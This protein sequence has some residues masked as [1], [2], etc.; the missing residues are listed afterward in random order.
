MAE[1]IGRKEE[2]RELARC[3]K[4]PKSEFVVVY[5]RRRIGKTF[6][7]RNFF[8]EKYDF[9]FVGQ[10]NCTKE[11]Q[12]ANFAEAIKRYG[13]TNYDLT[14]KTWKDAFNQLRILLENKKLR[15]KKVIFIDEM[16][17]LDSRRSDFVSALEYFWNAWAGNRDDIMFVACGSS[18]SWIVEKILKNRGGLF[19]RVTAQIYLRPFTL[20]EVKD[21]LRSLNF[22]WD[23][24]QI[25]QAYMIL[26]GVP[27]YYSLIDRNLPLAKNI[28]N[29]FFA[30]KNAI[31]RTEFDELF[32]ALFSN[33]EKHIDV[34]K[35]LTTC[36]EG[37]T[38]TEITQKVDFGGSEMTKILDNLE[39]CD[40]IMSSFKT[41]GGKKNKIYR[42]CDFYT[43]FYYKFVNG[44]R[45]SNADFWQQMSK[46]PKL[47][48]WQG[49]SFE[50]LCLL[51]IRQI[52]RALGIDGIM[53]E[54]S[55]WRSKNYDAQIDLVI[56]RSD[57]M[58]NLCE[59]KFSKNKFVL[60]PDYESTLR[61]RMGAFIAET[62]TNYGVNCSFITTYGVSNVNSH[63]I[64]NDNILLSDLFENQ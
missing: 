5:G 46:S 36:S 10:H 40:F 53:T 8:K 32:A 62:G 33:Y 27:F 25:A 22:N 20:R 55:T 14:L 42:I 30:S 60:T 17:W 2:C 64:I 11:E 21:Y 1:M 57:R 37:Y 63:S 6:L 9:S 3:M 39:R 34:I 29:L 50:L 31:L 44:N 52:Q 18:T 28:D 4:S 51:H 49:F 35:T 47:Y 59:M 56:E 15:R 7:I 23:N 24:Y 61:D 19:N 26:G 54:V 41:G 43:L 48:T 16:P 58:I 45:T 12:L 13:N 38:R